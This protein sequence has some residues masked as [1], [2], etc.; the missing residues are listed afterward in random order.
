M[1]EPRIFVVSGGMGTTGE[2]FARTA[3]AQ[4]EGSGVAIAVVPGIR[5]PAKFR[6]R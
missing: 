6:T 4:F 3:L 1:S 5:T 2:Q